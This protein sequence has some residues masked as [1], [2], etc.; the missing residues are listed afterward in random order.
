VQWD[1][2]NIRKA[3]LGDYFEACPLVAQV[4]EDN[5]VEHDCL[6][7]RF[8]NQSIETLHQGSLRQIL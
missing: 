2:K 8:T 3:F 7:K 1:Q 4:E 6:T 5:G